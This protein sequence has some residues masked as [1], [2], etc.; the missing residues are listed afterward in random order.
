ML[1]VLFEAPTKRESTQVFGY[2]GVGKYKYIKSDRRRIEFLLLLM[3]MLFTFNASHTK[4]S[5]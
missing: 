2:K 5:F 1:R 3:R 4:L